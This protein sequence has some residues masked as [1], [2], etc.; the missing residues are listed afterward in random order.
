[1]LEYRVKGLLS[2]CGLDALAYLL[3]RPPTAA[4]EWDRAGRLLTTAEA[5]HLSRHAVAD[6]AAERS[7]SRAS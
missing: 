1:V 5:N 2:S 7:G 4:S 3:P 6:L